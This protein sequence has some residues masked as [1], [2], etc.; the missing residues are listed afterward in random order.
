MWTDHIQGLYADDGRKEKPEIS[1]PMAAHMITEAEMKPAMAKMESG[2]VTGNDNTTFEL[3]I[4]LG[5]LGVEQLTEHSE[6]CL[7]VGPRFR[8]LKSISF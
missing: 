1:K 5:S 4:A 8:K 2:K 7:Q 6:P 3:L